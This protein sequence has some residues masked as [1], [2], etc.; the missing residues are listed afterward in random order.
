MKRFPK[1]LLLAM[2]A[3]T[4]V[5]S[6]SSCEDNNDNAPTTQDPSGPTDSAGRVIL[7]GEI[8]SSRT[9][10]ANEKYLLKGFVYVTSGNTLTIEPGTKIFGDQT[11]K[12]ALII[13]RGAKIVAEGAQSNPIVFTSSKAPG[14]RN[15]GDWGGLVLVGSAPINRSLST[16][17]EGGIRGNF[18]GTNVADNSGI[19]KYV[20]IEFA[21]VALSTMANSEING[22]TMYGV[23]SGTQIDYVQVSYSGD[24]SF[25]WFGGTVNAKHLVAYR[26]FDDDFDTDFGFTGKIQYGLSLRDPQYADQSGS[27]AFE[28]DNFNPGTPAT[29][30]NA[31]LPLTAPVFSNMSVFVTA[32]APPTTQAAGSGVYQSA[33]HLRRNTAI[34]I[35]NSVFSGYPE[36]L[37]LDGTSTWSNTV[38]TNTA[39]L[40]LRGITIAN[41]NTPLRSANNTGSGAFTDADVQTW[42]NGTGKNN[43]V[44]AS[45]GLMALGLNANSFNLNGPAFTL[46]SG[47]PLLTG[48][49]FTGKAA[50]SFFTN[51]TYRGAF[52]GSDNWTQGWANFDPQNASY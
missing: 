49:I 19:L 27:N 50:D 32:G 16:E 38:G 14:T 41:C 12:G 36:G 15:Y 44:V 40:D 45:T 21:G 30:D 47:S 5:S 24:D 31:G 9:L 29:G 7:E 25:E 52:N 1:M 13:E 22:L 8:T 3:M 46:Q 39:Q 51:G 37:R 4:S 33:M 28:S 17:M 2:L 6:L 20:R 10:R 26:G 42:F 11:T 48:A 35:Y 18:G 23:G 43:Q 34:S